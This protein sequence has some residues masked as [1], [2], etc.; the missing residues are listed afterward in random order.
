MTQMNISEIDVSIDELLDRGMSGHLPYESM[1][2]ET[3]VLKDPNSGLA[4]TLPT[5]A[6]SV[7]PTTP[8]TLSMNGPTGE[9][10]LNLGPHPISRLLSAS[11]SAV[12]STRSVF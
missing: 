7:I 8:R 9:E 12:S 4:H 1:V 10:L 2:K 3:V 5:P 11:S 6:T